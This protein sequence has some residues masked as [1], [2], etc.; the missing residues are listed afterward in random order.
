MADDRR[1]IISGLGYEQPTFTPLGRAATWAAFAV[2]VAGA[3]GSVALQSGYLLTVAEAVAFLVALPTYVV[4][5]RRRSAGRPGTGHPGRIPGIGWTNIVLLVLLPVFMTAY[6]AANAPLLGSHSVRG[7][8]DQFVPTVPVFI[9]PYL[10]TY[11]W[12]VS[13]A[14]FLAARLVDRQLRTMLVAGL[15]GVGIAITTF[16]LFQTDVDT[17]ALS[18]GSYADFLGSW[19]QYMDE[20]MF[21]MPDYG[22]FPSVHVLWSVTLAI[23]WVRRARPWWSVAAVVLAALIIVATQVLHQH[24]LMAAMYG[25]IVAVAT[26]S[27]SWW[28]LE[29]R[30]AM[31][32][33][34]HG[35][36]T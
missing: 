16:F 1:T 18:Q 12:V 23:A 19:M 2:M 3:W 22:D 17:V 31:R 26:Y 34:G 35:T 29:Y 30:P 13:T 25:A 8:W 9:V 14:T 28:L 36:L 5:Q 24:S 33:L 7:Y 27:V 10:F 6:G 11:V 4:L 15:L 21:A 32:R 20:H